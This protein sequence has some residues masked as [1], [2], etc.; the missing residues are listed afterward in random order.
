[1]SIRRMPSSVTRDCP[2]ASSRAISRRRH[3]PERAME[4][5]DTGAL[6]TESPDVPLPETASN[7]A[8]EHP[9]LW[10]AF[11]RLGEAASRAGPLDERTRRLVHLAFAI[12]TD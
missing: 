10:G 12:A 9:E 2:R 1:M 6:G 3:N 5:P 11:Q 4:R 8:R 7:V